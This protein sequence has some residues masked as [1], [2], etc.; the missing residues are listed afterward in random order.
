MSENFAIKI[1]SLQHLEICKKNLACEPA[2]NPRYNIHCF[3]V[4]LIFPCRLFSGICIECDERTFHSTYVLVKSQPLRVVI[5]LT[6]LISRLP[7][8]N[9]D[10]ANQSE[11]M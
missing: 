7:T 9:M 3:D 10:K 1:D 11:T 4:M 5:P 6:K 8:I 2:K